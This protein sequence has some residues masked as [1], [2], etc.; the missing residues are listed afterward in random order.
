MPKAPKKV[1]LLI[2]DIFLHFCPEGLAARAGVSLEV[3]RTLEIFPVWTSGTTNAGCPTYSEI[4]ERSGPEEE[5]LTIFHTRPGPVV[6]G[7]NIEDRLK[8]FDEV[9]CHTGGH[10]R[11]RDCR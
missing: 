6:H 5:C 7:E 4:V 8:D 2:D 9:G 10:L 3:I 11:L 1:Q